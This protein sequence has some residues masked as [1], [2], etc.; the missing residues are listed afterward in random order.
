MATPHVAGAAAL[1]LAA[2][3][4][5]TPSQVA[6]ALTNNATTG[7]VKSPGS[8][9]PN[10]CSTPASSAGAAGNQPPSANF[11][12]SLHQ[13]DCSFTDTST[14][15]RRHDRLALVD[16]GDG[17][18]ST[19]ANPSKTYA[20]AGTYTVTL[21]VTDNG[22]RTATTSQSVTFEQRRR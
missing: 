15:S 18:T 20:A 17:T 2:N 16:F 3:P 22:G 9:S 1:Y 19:A 13:P 10:S 14:D 5:A 11:T 12:R 21:T 8:G 7:V 4:A 6:A